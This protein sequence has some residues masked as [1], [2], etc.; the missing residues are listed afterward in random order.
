[1]TPDDDR[2]SGRYVG[3]DDATGGRGLFWVPPDAGPWERLPPIR[4][5]SVDGP[6]WGY[7]GN[8][9]TDAAEAILLHA[10]GDPVT[11]DRHARAFAADVLADQPIDHYLNLPATDVERWA[12]ERDV[13]LAPGWSPFGPQPVVRH[14][15]R[16]D[17]VERYVVALDGWDLLRIDLP[18]ESPTAVVGVTDL[19]GRSEF[20]WTGPVAAAEPG[21]GHEASQPGSRV[22]TDRLP[23]GGWAVQVE[24]FDV[25]IVERDSGRA[26]DARVAIYDRTLDSGFLVFDEFVR[27]RQVP[28]EPVEIGELLRRFSGTDATARFRGR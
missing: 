21:D 10:T 3:R 17:G 22:S 19:K 25:A 9:P 28:T 20:R 6:N 14:W 26:T 2:G 4:H 11:A 13:R 16:S 7:E 27:Y 23:F 1:M 15:R 18:A 12:R 5:R 24:G 8:G